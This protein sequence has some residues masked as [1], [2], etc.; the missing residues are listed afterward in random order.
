MSGGFLLVAIKNSCHCQLILF[1][2]QGEK[3]EYYEDNCIER[4]CY[5][6]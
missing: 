4:H 2:L 1:P 3:G 5:Q 6:E